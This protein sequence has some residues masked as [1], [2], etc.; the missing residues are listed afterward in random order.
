MRI[1]CDGQILAGIVLLSSIVLRTYMVCRR[2]QTCVF[3]LC[4]LPGLDKPLYFAGSL[5]P[6][7]AF[8][9]HSKA[10]FCFPV[11]C[12]LQLL[13][14]AHSLQHLHISSKTVFGPAHSFLKLV[15]TV[16]SRRSFF[17][18]PSQKGQYHLLKKKKKIAS[19]LTA[20]SALFPFHPSIYY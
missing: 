5:C 18:H 17:Q 16:R 12:P 19:E 20:G 1:R 15:F 13:F 7:K 3:R 8:S 9:S 10:S 6:T 4:R 2:P 11:R 14:S